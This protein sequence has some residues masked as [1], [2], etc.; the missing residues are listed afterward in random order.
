MF[1][2]TDNIP[3]DPQT[4]CEVMSQEI[5]H[6]YGLDHELLAADPMT[7][8]AFTGKRTFQDADASCGEKTARPC[9][10]GSTACRAQQNSRSRC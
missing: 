6:A 4:V 7:Y 10:P 1:A 9:G 3:S 2:F 5:G 8:L